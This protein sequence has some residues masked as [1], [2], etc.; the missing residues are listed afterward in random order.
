ME[1]RRS[2]SAQGRLAVN[3]QAWS[4]D[5]YGEG[6]DYMIDADEVSIGPEKN[7]DIKSNNT[8]GACCQPS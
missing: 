7:A 5:S 4:P 6:V 8:M 2:F 3:N 1:S